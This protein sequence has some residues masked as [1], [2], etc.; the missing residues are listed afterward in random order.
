V[1]GEAGRFEEGL[2]EEEPIIKIY[3]KKK[4]PFSI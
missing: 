2:G 4:N 1:G 3:C